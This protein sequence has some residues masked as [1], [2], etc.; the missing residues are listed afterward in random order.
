MNM[1]QARANPP[2]AFLRKA[3]LLKLQTAPGILSYTG[4]VWAKRDTLSLQRKLGVIKI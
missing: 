3:I 1:L 2:R 4:K